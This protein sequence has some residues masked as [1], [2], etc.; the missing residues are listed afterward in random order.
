MVIMVLN[1]MK[2]SKHILSELPVSI[3][4]LH[5]LKGLGLLADFDFRHV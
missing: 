5:F 3:L 1:S 2:K 4:F